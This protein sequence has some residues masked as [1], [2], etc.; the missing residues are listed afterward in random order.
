MSGRARIG[1]AT[2]SLQGVG[3]GYRHRADSLEHRPSTVL[4]AQARA[5]GPDADPGPAPV[6]RR[7]DAT[8]HPAGP[9]SSDGTAETLA[10]SATSHEDVA[11]AG[12]DDDP[13]P[14]IRANAADEIVEHVPQGR[15]NAL[16]GHV[17]DPSPAGPS[18]CTFSPCRRVE[19]GARAMSLQH[20]VGRGRA[21]VAAPPVSGGIILPL[22]RGRSPWR[23]ASSGHMLRFRR[24][25]C[26]GRSGQRPTQVPSKSQA[27]TRCSPSSRRP[28]RI[29]HP[30][31][32]S[33]TQTRF[34][35]AYAHT[36]GDAVVDG[37]VAG[38][39]ASPEERP[40]A[41][42]PKTSTA[43][44]A[45]V[46]QPSRGSD[47]GTD[48]VACTGASGPGYPRC[49]GAVAHGAAETPGGR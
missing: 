27:V 15:P 5:S 25:R 47:L 43:S 28:A 48:G 35:G 10:A 18:G 4:C 32:P 39:S 44:D 45:A 38:T 33:C 1:R 13:N 42:R 49:V 40:T 2:R 3:R 29:G 11:H 41:A 14:L 30:R 7:P 26:P 21:S 46:A 24:A 23:P 17:P 36:R 9:T 19:P 37:A 12:L 16:P 20:S 8:R 22:A 6:Q 34:G 31:G